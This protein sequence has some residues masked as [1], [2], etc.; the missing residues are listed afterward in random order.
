MK[1]RALIAVSMLFF[2]SATFAQDPL[3][4]RVFQDGLWLGG[5]V[6]W[7]NLD[8]SGGGDDDAWGYNL[9]VGWQFLRYFGVSAK[10]KDLGEFK[11]GPAKADVDGFTLGL[12]AGYPVT[13]RIAIHG[14]LGYY[15][16]DVKAS[17]SGSPSVSD[18]DDGLYLSAGVSSQVGRVII[19]PMFVWYDTSDADLYSIELNAYWKFGFG[20]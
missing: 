8:I 12:G 10:W 7:S 11:D 18:G 3:D 1:I 17:V 9:G 4:A 6:N 13:P 15:D 20:Q 2:A 19:Q 5:G 16:F 14:G